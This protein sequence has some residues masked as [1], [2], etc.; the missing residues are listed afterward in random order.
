MTDSSEMLT[1]QQLIELTG[2]TKASAQVKQ[3]NQ[4]KI[5]Y[6]LRGDGKPVVTWTAVNYPFI[7][8]TTENVNQPNFK[9]MR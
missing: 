7:K 2:Y 9:A 5:N 8:R 4:Q 6:H 1:E 3:L